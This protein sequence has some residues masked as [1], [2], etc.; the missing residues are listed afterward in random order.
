[1]LYSNPTRPRFLRT[2]RYLSGVIGSSQDVDQRLNGPRTIAGHSKIRG[3]VLSREATLGAEDASALPRS[4]GELP[5]PN[6][7]RPAGLI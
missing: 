4:R 3:I 2:G 5:E 6:L 7:E 1:M